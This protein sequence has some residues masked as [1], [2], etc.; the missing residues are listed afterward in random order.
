MISVAKYNMYNPIRAY[1]KHKKTLLTNFFETKTIEKKIKN[2]S[3]INTK[4]AFNDI[5]FLPVFLFL[6]L[7]GV[8]ADFWFQV[9]RTG[10][11]EKLSRT[12]GTTANLVA[13]AK[14]NDKL[15]QSCAKLRRS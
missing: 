15:G 12:V 13:V 7:F 14:M 5:Y 1:K 4:D 9:K 6:R 11:E 3:N 8:C 2:L 10:K